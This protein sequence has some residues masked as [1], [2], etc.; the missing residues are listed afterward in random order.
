MER[1]MLFFKEIVNFQTDIIIVAS[2]K[3]ATL[4]QILKELQIS[5]GS[6]VKKI[7][8]KVNC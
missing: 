6:K 7:K 3:T 5:L 2:H 1:Y 4:Q 8:F